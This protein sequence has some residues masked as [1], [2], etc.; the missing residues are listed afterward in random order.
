MFTPP[1]PE[2]EDTITLFWSIIF[3]L[4]LGLVVAA[5]LAW[6]FLALYGAEWSGFG[7]SVIN[8][9]DTTTIE[10]EYRPAKTLWDWLELLIVPAALAGAVY[11]LNW[12]ERRS[13]DAAE[14]QHRE[15]EQAIET[16]R[17]ENEQRITQRRYE[18]E[19][20][21]AQNQLQ[22]NALQNY[23]D[24]MT[25]L[26]LDKDEKLHTAP[27]NPLSPSDPNNP[28]DPTIVTMRNI[29]R[30]R[31]LTV[32]RQLDGERKGIVI[33]FLWEAS[34]IAATQ[35]VIR[36]VDAELSDVKLPNTQLW[37]AD[38]RG[39]TL[40][41][42]NLAGSNLDQTILADAILTNQADLQYTILTDANMAGANMAGAYL[43]RA[44][45]RGA[46]L[47]GANL[48]DAYLIGATLTGADLQGATLTGAD[49]RGAD[50]TGIVNADLTGAMLS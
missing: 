39:A 20:R 38:L 41:G 30:T 34:L 50:L 15:N 14:Q 4:L 25:E 32:L 11:L 3:R 10:P 9:P 28:P 29:A 46:N 1:Q 44:D 47:R 8:P 2:H 23:F 5:A 18:N 37:G 19:Q 26:M 40:T 49:L 13:R 7:S 36:L 6:L 42:A 17:Y 45:L 35:A 31:T 48:A 24:R 33:R 12:L 22:E 43:M 21:I 27:P 16:Q